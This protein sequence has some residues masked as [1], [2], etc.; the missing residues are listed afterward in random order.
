MAQTTELYFLTVVGASKTEGLANSVSGEESSPSLQMTII[1]LNFYMSEADR[2]KQRDREKEREKEKALV[3]PF[4][5][6]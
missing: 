2:E 6:H 5:G 1:S 3:S 4:K